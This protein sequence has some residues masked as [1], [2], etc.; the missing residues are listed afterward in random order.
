MKII[1]VEHRIIFAVITIN[2]IMN[3]TVF[4]YLFT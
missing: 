4:Y 1:D 3:A 2:L